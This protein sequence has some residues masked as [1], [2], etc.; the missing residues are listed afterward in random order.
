MKVKLEKG[1]KWRDNM[2][3]IKS[4]LGSKKEPYVKTEEEMLED[5]EY[6]YESLSISEKSI[7]NKLK[8]TEDGNRK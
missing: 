7:Y 2:S 6:T 8:T 1:R 5:K 4:R 3:P